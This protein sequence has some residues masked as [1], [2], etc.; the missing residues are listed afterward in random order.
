MKGVYVL[1][2]ELPN[3]SDVELG[4]SGKGKTKFK[5]GFYAYVGSA[6]NGLEKRIER[7]LRKEKKLYWHIDYLLEK[8]E[9]VKVI[10]AETCLKMECKI[11]GNLA[12]NL[13]YINNFGCSDCGC[14]SHL[15]YC[16]DFDNLK[17][18][19]LISF[20]E[21]RLKPEFYI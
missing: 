9:I 8:A 21:N 16:T 14:E 3:N 12:G 17:N 18:L 15:F 10:Y 19:I 1:I 11:A 13:H 7:H 2:I 4:K 5:S 20:K 6:L